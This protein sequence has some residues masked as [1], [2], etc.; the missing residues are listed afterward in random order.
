M[1]IHRYKQNPG[2]RSLSLWEGFIPTT[3]WLW[4]LIATVAFIAGTQQEALASTY[5][6]DPEQGS[7]SASGS[8]TQPWRSLAKA[9]D[10]VV[11]GDTVILANGHYGTWEIAAPS[12][13]RTDWITFRAQNKH[14]AKFDRI[15]ILHDGSNLDYHLRFEGLQISVPV[16]NPMPE[17][18]G[19]WHYSNYSHPVDCVNANYVEF[20]DCI[21]EGFNKYFVQRAMSIRSCNYV[22]VDECEM[23]TMVGGIEIQDSTHSTIWLLHQSFGGQQRYTDP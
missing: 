9:Q 2:R 22:V 1:Y 20:H 16:P 5:F 12:S 8:Q 10:A 7:D 3:G 4:L 21:M 18:D 14:E 11:S 15:S 19:Y 6:I 23:R 13:A 17:P